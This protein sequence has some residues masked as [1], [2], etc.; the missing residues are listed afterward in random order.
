MRRRLALVC[1]L[2]LVALAGWAPGAVA[3]DQ[4]SSERLRIRSIDSTDPTDVRMVVE[5]SGDPAALE[6]ATI[7]ENG[8]ERSVNAVS[9]LPATR[10]ALVIAVD[11]SEAM[12]AGGALVQTREAVSAIIRDAPEGQTIGLVSFGGN[13]ARVVQRL[14]TDRERLLAAVENLAPSGGSSLLNGVVTASDLVA[15]GEGRQREIILVAGGPITSSTVT[16]SRARGALVTSRATLYTLGLEN[17][18]VDGGTLRS[19]TDATGGIY[20]AQ[21]SPSA[22]A[23]VLEGYAAVVAD[24]HVLTYASAEG[25][26]PVDLELDVA[27][28]ST[29]VSFVSGGV[30]EG[31][32]N[33]RPVTASEP[34]GVG[35]LRDNGLL[36]GIGLV[37]LAVA[38]AIYAVVSLLT[39]DAGSLDAVL[40]QYTEPAAPSPYDDEGDSSLAKTA[41]IQRAVSLTE[42][43]A[44]RQGLLAKIEAMLERANLPLRA[45]EA[46]FFY[47]AGVGLLLLLAL[48][49]TRNLLGA[50][51]VVLIG[52]LIP[53]A[54]VNFLASRRQKAFES[55]LPDT[56]QLLSGTLRAGYSLMQG[57][58][59]VSR[60]VSEPMG[61]ELRR[62]VTESRLGRPLEESLEA[63]A[64]RMDS[65]DFAW[66][67]MA[68]RIQ[69]EV[70]GNL[71]ELLL[72]VADTMTQ[73][74]RLRRDVAALTAEGKISAIVLGLLPIGLGIAMWML[75]RDYISALFDTRLGNFLL[76][77]AI[78]LAGVGFYW[79]KKV[80]EVDI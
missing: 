72:T 39:P 77:G 68:I 52:I 22:I 74:E 78:I 69:R 8:E 26:G 12:D 45:A 60:E 30:A 3:Q 23:D 56:L 64:E 4:D 1:A 53:P 5:Y 2:L 46:L 16:G 80:I 20:T 42:G 37:L 41:F 10:S 14:T 15:T 57:V 79:M 40:E 76:G 63:S 59:A 6:G 13:A 48:V 32:A 58:E 49:L 11:T 25:T 34:G 47:A 28:A 35:F 43:F 54:V 70:G 9:A 27:D 24:N 62:V 21:E 18:G 65:G 44:E 73:R 7:R 67:V 51:V 66:A 71:A 38:L 31:A 17:R 36:I 55:Q 29:S 75:N 19:L 50:V 61:Q 33:L